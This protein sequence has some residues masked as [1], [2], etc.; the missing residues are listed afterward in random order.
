MSVTK[1]QATINGVNGTITGVLVESYTYSESFNG[2]E[3][4]VGQDGVVIGLRYFDKRKQVNL[5]GVVPTSYS[6]G[7][8][9]TVSFNGNGRAVNGALENLEERGEAKGALRVTFTIVEYEGVSY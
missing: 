1:G 2:K 6:Q 5:T 8:A 4:I 9:D 3:E 7:A